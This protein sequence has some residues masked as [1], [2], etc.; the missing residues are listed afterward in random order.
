MPLASAAGSP[1]M[2]SVFNRAVPPTTT[3]TADRG[4]PSALATSRSSA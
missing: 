3:E 1:E 2:R 4:T